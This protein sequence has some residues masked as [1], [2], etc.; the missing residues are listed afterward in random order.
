LRTAFPRPCRSALPVIGD[1]LAKKCKQPATIDG[2][3]HPASSRYGS[4]GTA[5]QMIEK[6]LRYPS[7]VSAAETPPRPD[8]GQRADGEVN[9]SIASERIFKIAHAF[10]EAKALFSA[11]ELGVFT[12]LADGP[13][14]YERLCNRTGLHE[15]GARDFLDSLVALGLLDRQ[16]DGRYRNT[17]EADTYLSRHSTSYVG[18]LIDY[19]NAREYP[20]WM[21]LT[22]A[23]QT[24][25]SQFGDRGPCHFAPRGMLYAN[26]ADVETFAHA[27]N[28]GTIAIARALAT[29]FPWRDYSTLIDIGSAEGCLPVQIAQFHWH[30]SGGGFDLPAVGPVFNAYVDNHG[31]SQRLRFYPGDFLVNEFPSA[32]VL[33]MGRV[34][35]DWDLPTKKILLTKAY[36]AL[37]SGGALVVY[38]RLIDDGMKGSTAGLLGNLN[39]L[40]MTDGGFDYSAAECFGWMKEAGFCRTWSEPLTADQSMVVGIK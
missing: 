19:L 23:L 31:L 34:L 37:P 32:D 24:G 30:I 33:V 18:G 8:H 22:R 27:M 17:P 3:E 25:Y 15:R 26:Q 5:M 28:G 9:R 16:E 29:R 4:E 36:A 13:L 2:D 39:M 11:V 21:F 20:H 35:H 1:E 12:A 10:R 6:T 14:D 7:A 38:E 40:V